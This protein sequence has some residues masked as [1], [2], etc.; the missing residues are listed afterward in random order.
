METKQTLGWQNRGK[1]YKAK[2]LEH[3]KALYASGT[4][5]ILETEAPKSDDSDTIAAWIGECTTKEIV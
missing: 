1:V 3:L 4:P 2:T 5:A